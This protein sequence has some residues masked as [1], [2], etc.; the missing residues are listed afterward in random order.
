M[1]Y[2][3]SVIIILLFSPMMAIFANNNL[4][5]AVSIVPCPVQI[6]PGEGHFCFSEKTVFTV[7]NEEQAKI[8]EDFISLFSRAAGFT[9]VLKIGGEGNIRFLT[10]NKLPEEAYRLVITPEIIEIKASGTKGLFYGLQTLRML[11]PASIEGNGESDIEWNVPAVSIEDE[12][13]FAYRGLMLDVS[14]CFIP[15]ENVMRIIDCMSMLKINKLHFH[16][17]DDNGW[18][19][20]IKKYPLLTKVGAWRVDRTE[21]PFPLRRNQKPGEPAPIGGFYTQ[22]DIKEIVTYAMRRHIEI[23][24]EIEMPAHTN[25]S[26]AAYPG[27][28]C[29]IV[30]N[31]I[32]VIPGLGGNNPGVIYCAGNDSVF[33]F[34]QDVIDEVLELFPSRYIHLGGDEASKVNWKKCPLCQNRM[35]K[36]HLRNEEDLQG[37]FMK[38]MSEYVRSKGKEVMGWDELTNSFIPEG[39]VLFGWRGMGTAALEAAEKGHRFVM[40]PA[41]VMYLIRYQGPQWFEPLTYFGNNTLK[42]IFDYEPVQENWKPEYKSLLMG[43]QASMWT[44]FCDKPED[45]D[46]L[47][48]PRLAALAERAWT[49]PEKKNWSS[50]LKALD[51]YNAHIEEKGI[52]YARS[53]YNIQHTVTSKDGALV[54]NLECIR[55]DVE[56]RY[57]VDG[58]EPTVLSACYRKPVILKEAG[59]VKCATFVGEKKMGKTL[60]LPV[61]WNKA[62]GKPVFGDNKNVEVV[63]NGIRGSLKQTDYEWASWEKSDTV[64]FTIDLLKKETLHTV[65]VGCITNYGMAIHKPASIEVEISDDNRKFRKAGTL[66]FTPQEIFREWNF[67]ED[68]SLNINGKQAR[69]IRVTAK[70]PGACPEDH[71]RPGQESR[72][73]FDEVIVK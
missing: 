61:I 35:K 37:Y 72:V 69:Y 33:T 29:P 5:Q 39:A 17:V 6:V 73:M 55:P 20:E 26:L 15:K 57:T 53:M 10:E 4:T 7:G 28:A 64:S 2:T 67:V 51:V 71:V 16:L 47:L 68:L 36:E 44:E 46:Y 65:T 62:T 13:R 66:S 30:K 41:R 27:L 45:V 31:Y 12:P 9:P 63:T 32:G 19:L 48:F 52:C 38:R 14:R 8:A 59:T 24:P 11:L 49:Q 18:R 42:D 56:I 23:I 3:L 43:I 25:S 21:L 54:V 60:I 22:E 40:T 34:L 1:K 58:K 50:F 70:G